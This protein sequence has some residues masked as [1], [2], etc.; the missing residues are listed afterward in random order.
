MSSMLYGVASWSRRK[1]EVVGNANRGSE[2]V[3]VVIVALL[4]VAMTLSGAA[5]GQVPQM[6]PVEPNSDLGQRAI[7]LAQTR[8]DEEGL[9]RAKYMI[10]V[11]KF[12]KG[13]AVLF[14]DTTTDATR[15][16]PVNDLYVF[17]DPDASRIMFDFYWTPPRRP[18]RH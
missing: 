17:L 7:A 12:D 11:A 10:G 8:F 4:V 18:D 2:R 16:P 14:H 6:T 3:R 13:L 9:D 1:A 15:S 5:R